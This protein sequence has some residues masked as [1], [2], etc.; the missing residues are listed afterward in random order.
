MTKTYEEINKKIKDGVAVILTAEEMVELVENEGVE[1]AAEEVD[2]VTTGTFGCMCSSGVFFNIPQPDPPIKME[3]VVIDGINAYHGNAAADF[4]L[5]VTQTSSENENFGG[6]HVLESLL[7]R[8]SVQIEV[9][10]AGT[11]CYPR[12]SLNVR[13]KLKNFNQAIMINPR[14][15]YQRYVCAVNNSGEILYTYM[16]KLLPNLQN[17]AYGGVG[18]MSPLNNDPTYQTIGL[19]TS[20]FLGGALGTIIGPGTQHNPRSQMGNIMVTGNLKEMSPEFIAGAAISGYG[21]SCFIGLGIPIPIINEGLARTCG[22]P[23]SEIFT[24][25]LDYST[26]ERERPLL[27]EVSYEELKSRVIEIEGKQIP[28]SSTSSYAKSRQ[29]TKILKKWSKQGVISFRPPVLP[30]PRETEFKNLS[31]EDYEGNE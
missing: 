11:D 2:V 26:R 3:T 21:S 9:T 22:T 7:R 5:G 18:T 29:I 12:K 25:V 17:G 14:N 30:L 24:S 23:D 27:R 28:V 16:G 13:L 15:A 10:G 8:K 6:G 19:G 1:Y 31:Q 4:Y 20:I